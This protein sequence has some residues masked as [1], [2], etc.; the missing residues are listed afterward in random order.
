MCTSEEFLLNPMYIW[1]S[2]FTLTM[3]LFLL[4][5]HDSY[6]P[7]NNVVPFPFDLGMQAQ[8]ISYSNLMYCYFLDIFEEPSL[9]TIILSFH[10]SKTKVFFYFRI[11]S[12]YWSFWNDVWI[13][14]VW[15]IWGWMKSHFNDLHHRHEISVGGLIQ[16]DLNWYLVIWSTI[17]INSMIIVHSSLI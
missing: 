7:C 15:I 11:L 5:N 12:I 13:R 4:L 6:S 10:C 3:R 2:L 14:S 8:K 16:T 17:A 1:T 9:H